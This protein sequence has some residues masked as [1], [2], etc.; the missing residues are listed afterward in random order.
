[1]NDTKAPK[2][3]KTAETPLERAR[4]LYR[5]TPSAA[6]ARHFINELEQTVVALEGD[7]AHLVARVHASAAAAS[8][9]ATAQRTAEEKTKSTAEQAN[10]Q[11]SLVIERAAMF[12]ALAETHHAELL[13]LRRQT[14]DQ[15]DD[16]RT[17]GQALAD[18]EHAR[19]LAE[20]AYHALRSIH[21]G[22]RTVP[23]PVV[24]SLSVRDV[25]W[26]DCI[27]YGVRWGEVLLG[28]DLT[29]GPARAFCARVTEAIEAVWKANDWP[30]H[31][32][33]AEKIDEAEKKNEQASE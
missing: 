29:F 6:H 9:L 17:M 25:I 4:R 14:A 27:V 7:A 30:L 26:A 5:T 10:A 2:K 13:A 23:R 15:A 16:L 20:D 22:G 1:M 3:N 19:A 21:P 24:V 31:W 12:Q 8:Q 18:A 28:E 32:E 33:G 11:L